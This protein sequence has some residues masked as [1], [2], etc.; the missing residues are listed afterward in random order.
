MTN[1]RA[2]LLAVLIGFG[3]TFTASADELVSRKRVLFLSS[4]H[5]GFPTF[6]SQVEGLRRGLAEKGFNEKNL[7][8]DIEFL[9]AK[10]FSPAQQVPMVATLLARKFANFVPYDLVVTGD[11]HA[12]KL[13]V[14]RQDDL[15][16]GSPIVFLGANNAKAGLAQNANPRVTGVVEHYS[17]LETL[18]MIQRLYPMS[19]HVVIVSDATEIGD[20]GAA[21][22]RAAAAR[23]RLSNLE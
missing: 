17:I 21:N 5:P 2:L 9:D 22:V 7:V 23:L 13:A 3:C 15:L 14:A 12:F 18:Q 4:Y 1:Y 16:R 8:L 6:F 20:I 10:R 19:G 11:D